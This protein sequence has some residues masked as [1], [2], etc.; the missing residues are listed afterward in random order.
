[1]E[2]IDPIWLFGAI[3][4][5]G[6]ILLGVLLL[7][8]FNPKTGDVEKLQAELDQA[9]K[10]MESYKASVN[11]HFNKTSDLVNELTQDYVK[12]YRHLAEG[13]QTLSDTREFT[14]VLDQPQGQVLITVEAPVEPVPDPDPLVSEAEQA[15]D[16]DPLA[17]QAGQP[18]TPVDDDAISEGSDAA[19]T[20][21]ADDSPEPPADYARVDD[22]G[23]ETAETVSA[24]TESVAGTN[25]D[26]DE[27]VAAVSADEVTPGENV[28]AKATD[29]E[30]QAV[31]DE[32]ETD[33]TRKT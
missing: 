21:V 23:T 16:P 1:V 29:A 7:R 32:T 19:Q 17:A 12:V 11:S 24:D 31:A 4:L 33:S 26:A 9:H 3:F 6:G 18:P 20:S 15:P 28:T 22:S 10:D 8:L 13:A 27:D 14:Q 25:K 2:S 30:Q 5:A